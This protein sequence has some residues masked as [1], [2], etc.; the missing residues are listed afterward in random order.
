MSD[1]YTSALTL[2]ED[3]SGEIEDLKSRGLRF[4]EKGLKVLGVA[5]AATAM[6][7]GALLLYLHIQPMSSFSTLDL[8][9][10]GEAIANVS[11]SSSASSPFGGAESPFQTPFDILRGVMTSTV[12]KGLAVLGMVMGGMVAMVRGSIAAAIPAI[13]FGSSFMILPTMIDAI[14]PGGSAPSSQQANGNNFLRQLVDEKRYKE[15]AGAAGDLMPSAQAAY[16]KAQIA[17]LTKDSDT[18]KNELGA[19]AGSKLEKWSPDWERMNVLETEAYGSPKIQGTV[20]F[21]ADVQSSM[22][23]REKFFS[24]GS[25]VAIISGLIGGSLFGFGMMLVWRARR[26]EEMLGLDQKKEAPSVPALEDVRSQP[27]EFEKI[28]KAEWV[29]AW[30]RPIQ[31]FTR[32]PAAPPTPVESSSPS[33]MDGLLVGAAAGMVA[34]ALLDDDRPVRNTTDSGPVFCPAPDAAPACADGGD[35]GAGGCE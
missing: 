11:S 29:P 35:C 16:L 31:P 14:A 30:Q 27:L 34:S 19:L 1:A 5:A 23:T 13:I 9:A 18:L 33:I 28:E 8:P 12:A 26:L 3:T 17:Y 10:L 6:A 7:I 25:F 20:R 32:E 22:K 21:A 24:A 15:L 2:P 4:R